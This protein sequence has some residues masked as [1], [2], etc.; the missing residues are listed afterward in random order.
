MEW[1]VGFP[2]GWSQ[3]LDFYAGLAYGLELAHTKLWNL[4]FPDPMVLFQNH[5][6]YKIHC[7]S[8][9]LGV[10]WSAQLAGVLHY[11]DWLHWK[12]QFAFT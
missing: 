10:G 3:A 9:V 8:L 1:W 7:S 5:V 11:H 6:D 12:K 2:A 4:L